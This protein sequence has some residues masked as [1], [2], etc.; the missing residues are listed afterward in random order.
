MHVLTPPF[1]EKDV[2]MFDWENL[3]ASQEAASV[4]SPPPSAP[5]N[6]SALLSPGNM[7]NS[8]MSTTIGH[9]SSTNVLEDGLLPLQQR[10]KKKR[11]KKHKIDKKI[12]LSNVE[13]QAQF[14]DTSE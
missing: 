12:S 10:E 8:S 6:Q 11:S 1:I 3:D 13:M 9:N 5:E 7:I 4:S 14:D 2:P